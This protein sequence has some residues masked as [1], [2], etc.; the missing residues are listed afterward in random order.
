[1]DIVTGLSLSRVLDIGVT[2]DLPARID[3]RA[4]LVATI[5]KIE[6]GSFALAQDDSNA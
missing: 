3:A 1:M 2:S 4:A 5:A 6:M